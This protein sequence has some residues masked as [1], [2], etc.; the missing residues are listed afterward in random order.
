[1]NF[2]DEENDMDDNTEDALSIKKE[3]LKLSNTIMVN[4]YEIWGDE[5]FSPSEEN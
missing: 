1:M 5:G 2:K 3:K 4:Q